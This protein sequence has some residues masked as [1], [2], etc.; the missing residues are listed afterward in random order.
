MYITVEGARIYLVDEGQGQ[1]VLSLHGNPDSADMWR[2][3]ITQ[4]QGE[5]R[6]LAIDLPGF[7]RSEVPAQF[8]ASLESEAQFIA[9]LVSVLGITQ[10]LDIVGHD[11]GGHFALAWAIRHP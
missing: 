4:L 6:C 3:V 10:P 1:P 5:Y 7:G 11:F 8:D 9:D 2:G